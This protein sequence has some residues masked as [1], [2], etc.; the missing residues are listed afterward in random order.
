MGVVGF[1]QRGSVL[2][3]KQFGGAG[4]V[5]FGHLGSLL[6]GKHLG[7]EVVGGKYVGGFNVVGLGG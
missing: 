4:V 1:G 7:S 2:P 3:R 6:P 5:G